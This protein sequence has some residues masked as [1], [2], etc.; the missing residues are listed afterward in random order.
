MF[1]IVDAVLLI[2]MLAQNYSWNIQKL[3]VMMW[4]YVTSSLPET[5][6]ETLQIYLQSNI[7][8]RENCDEHHYICC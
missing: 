6:G 3:D 7:K 5:D 2:C 8:T 4:Q 1:S